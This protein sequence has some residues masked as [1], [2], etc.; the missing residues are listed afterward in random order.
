MNSFANSGLSCIMLYYVIGVASSFSGKVTYFV[1][2]ID[3]ACLWIHF[4]SEFVYTLLYVLFIPLEE[5][6]RTSFEVDQV[7]ESAVLIEWCQCLLFRIPRS[8]YFIVPPVLS[9]E[10]AIFLNE[11]KNKIEEKKMEDEEQKKRGRRK[12]RNMFLQ[13]PIFGTT[14]FGRMTWY[15]RNTLERCIWSPRRCIFIMRKLVCPT[16]NSNQAN[17]NTMY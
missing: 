4:L 15:I 8:F 10:L 3:W 5:D 1:P 9:F 7:F 14:T 2:Q 6:D 17:I 16:S 11:K 13:K 12:Q